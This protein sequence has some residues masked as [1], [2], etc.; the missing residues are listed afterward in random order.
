VWT[1][2]GWAEIKSVRLGDVVLIDVVLIDVVLID[3]VLI[4][5]TGGRVFRCGYLD[6]VRCRAAP[7]TLTA[8]DAPRAYRTWCCCLSRRLSA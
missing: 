1:G 6:A 4:T 7:P 3:V 2:D 8:R 5:V